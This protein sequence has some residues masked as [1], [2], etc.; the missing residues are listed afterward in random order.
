MVQ[1]GIFGPDKVPDVVKVSEFMEKTTGWRL[2]PAS[3][4]CSA[5]EFLSCLAFRCFPCVLYIRHHSQPGYSPEPDVIHE[6]LGC[7]SI[8]NLC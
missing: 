7:Y 2:W 1:V 4:L 6:L 8:N 5:R 3:G